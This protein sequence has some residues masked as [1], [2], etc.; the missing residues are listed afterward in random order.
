MPDQHPSEGRGRL[1]RDVCE[2]YHRGQ[3]DSS[4]APSDEVLRFYG[5][6]PFC[7]SRWNVRNN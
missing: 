6:Y 2:T 3:I 1:V 7:D 4:A 5:G